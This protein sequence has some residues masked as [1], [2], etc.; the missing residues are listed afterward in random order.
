MLAVGVEL[1][2]FCELETHKKVPLTYL[3]KQ[4][5]MIRTNSYPACLMIKRVYVGLIIKI[6]KAKLFFE[7]SLF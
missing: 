5:Y 4:K 6:L 1:A 7:E 2:A 3:M